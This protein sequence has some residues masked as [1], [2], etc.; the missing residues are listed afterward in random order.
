MATKMPMDLRDALRRF[1]SKSLS[2]QELVEGS[3]E[4]AA[5]LQPRIQG[6]LHLDA[7]GARAA[8]R[9]CDPALPLAGIPV[10]FKD[11]FDVAGQP[12]TGNSRV[13]EG[14]TATHDA[15]S[16]EALRAAGAIVRTFAR[17]RS[18]GAPGGC[19]TRGAGHAGGAGERSGPARALR[20]RRSRA[21]RHRRETCR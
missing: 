9:D 1:R 18:R 14:R 2:P 16:V 4:R 6:F 10:G 15:P 17:F 12:A 20:R 3:L 7:E 5:S 21:A 19:G 11:L 8:A 13:F